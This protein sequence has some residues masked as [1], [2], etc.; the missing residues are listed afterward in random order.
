MTFKLILCVKLIVFADQH[1]VS[2]KLLDITTVEALPTLTHK[3][4]VTW[5]CLHALTPSLETFFYRLPT[6]VQY[7]P[8]Y[9]YVT[10]VTN[11][12]YSR[13]RVV[14]YS[15]RAV[16]LHCTHVYTQAIQL[17]IVRDKTAIQPRCN[18]AFMSYHTDCKYNVSR[19][20]GIHVHRSLLI[21]IKKSGE[22]L[23][24]ITVLKGNIKNAPKLVPKANVASS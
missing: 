8:R 21:T 9:T 2:I 20:E 3:S 12:M 23:T 4:P 11:Q 19:H 17:W 6:S 24:T 16:G 22:S 18:A 14:S 7:R 1:N 13:A 15:Y 10:M 5:C